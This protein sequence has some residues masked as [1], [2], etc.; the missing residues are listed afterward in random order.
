[1]NLALV[2]SLSIEGR[3]YAGTFAILPAKLADEVAAE[4]AKQTE[5][6]DWVE[7]KV[8]EGRSILIFP[9]GTRTAPGAKR[10]YHPGVAA[11]YGK[12]GLPVVPVALNSGLF[13]PRRGFVKRPGR[14]V[15]EFLPP[16]APGMEREV[17]A[18]ALNEA[19][20]TASTELLGHSRP[21]PS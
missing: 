5:F 12:L 2:K 17:F 11:L 3:V 21:E 6:E 7:E 15:L 10:A 9:E 20:E 16:I 13:W 18:T 4:A 1:M 8:K 14:I 19:I